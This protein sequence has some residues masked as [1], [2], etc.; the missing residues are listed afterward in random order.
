VPWTSGEAR[1]AAVVHV[2]DTLEALFDSAQQAGAG[3]I[4][5]RPALVVGQH[6][7]HDP[8]RAPQDKHTLYVYA[9]IPQA[10]DLAKGDIATLI[11][12]RIEEFA[13]GLGAL[14]RARCA[15][16]PR[17]LEQENPALVAGDLAAG[18]MELDQQLIFRPAPELCHYRS[19]LRGLYVAGGSTHPG[20]GVQ[21]VSGD[22]AARAVLADL[23]VRR[24]H[25]SWSEVRASSSP[26]P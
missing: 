10:P 12:Q 11:E 2:G 26:R 13:P 5:A 14:I 18:S 3:R 15:R 21:G 25:G 6:S 1:Q 7:L 19:P 17:E 22:G 20:P 24:L 9:R 23:R 16:S 4:P 8:T